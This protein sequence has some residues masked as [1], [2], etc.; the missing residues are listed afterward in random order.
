MNNYGSFV[1]VNATQ[2]SHL[3]LTSNWVNDEARAYVLLINKR[4]YRA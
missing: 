4:K 3:N 2:E 1:A